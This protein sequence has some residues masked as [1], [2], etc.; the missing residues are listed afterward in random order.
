MA[1]EEAHCWNIQAKFYNEKFPL[2][3][4]RQLLRLTIWKTM[5]LLW[6]TIYE[7]H[8]MKNKVLLWSTS[9]EKE[10]V[11]FPFLFIYIFLGLPFLI[12]PFS[13]FWGQCSINYDHHTFIYLQLNDY[14]SILE[15]RWLYMNASGG[16][17]GYAMNQ[18][19][20][21]W[22]NYEWWLCHKYYVNYMIMLSNMTMR[23]VSW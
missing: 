9:V 6:S 19:W 13:L 21:V 22:K 16:V 5:A 15:Q 14:N 23:N 12:W 10:T 8:Y 2:V 4:K 11:T 20:H 3:K 7:T 18:E 17:P 1:F